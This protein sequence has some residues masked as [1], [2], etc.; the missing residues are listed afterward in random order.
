MR[1]WF[2]ESYFVGARKL[3]FGLPKE[4]A[5]QAGGMQNFDTDFGANTLLRGDD[6]EM[7]K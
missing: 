6:I 3:K 4:V 1:H 2:T 7:D 5:L